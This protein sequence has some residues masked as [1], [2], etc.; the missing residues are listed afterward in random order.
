MDASESNSDPAK[1][2]TTITYHSKILP[3]LVATYIVLAQVVSAMCCRT[4]TSSGY[5]IWANMTR[6]ILMLGWVTEPNRQITGSLQP[7]SRQV[8][9]GEPCAAYL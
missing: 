5:R 3:L 6:P 2:A 1:G 7:D 8:A 4:I 9:G